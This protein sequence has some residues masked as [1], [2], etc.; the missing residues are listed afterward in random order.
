VV[1]HVPVE[2]DAEHGMAAF[3]DVQ[4]LD[5]SRHRI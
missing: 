4:H 3:M 1:A 2:L 5:N